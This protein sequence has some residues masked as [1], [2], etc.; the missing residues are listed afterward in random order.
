M[1]TPARGPLDPTDDQRIIAMTRQGYSA[2]RIAE[3][4]NTTARTIVRH[5]NALGIAQAS[6]PPHP[7]EV[8]DRAKELLDDGA[9]YSEVARTVG[10][11]ITQISRWHPGRGWDG[12]TCTEYATLCRTS[13]HLLTSGR[14]A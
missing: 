7:K 1:T 13:A 3:A 10:A 8:R 12:H 4:L 5:R 11:S 9:S 14:T 6:N 2:R